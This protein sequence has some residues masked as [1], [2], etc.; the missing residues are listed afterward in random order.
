MS[1][2]R[3]CL[4]IIPPIIIVLDQWTKT[5]ILDHVAFGTGFA[6]IP[7]IF[8]IVHVKNTGAAF[9]L[10]AGASDTWRNPFFYLIAVV[11]VAIIISTYR[12]ISARERLVP[13]VLGLILGGL[14]GN[15]IDRVRLGAVTD[16]LSFHW[17][18]AALTLNLGSRAFVM[19][20][21]WP[22]FNVADSA[23]TTSMVLLAWHFLRSPKHNTTVE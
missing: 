10:F 19:P 2:K 6:V 13:V 8:D 1:F 22:A 9:G 21:S 12:S 16:F 3:A 14:I 23:I 7:G 4:L 15:L 5:W 20:L 11:A 18:D 17:H